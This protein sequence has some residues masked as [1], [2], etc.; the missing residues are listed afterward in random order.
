M[1][2]DTH[3][4]L[5]ENAFAFDRAD[6]VAAA[7]AAGVTRIVTIGTTL[8]SSR[9]ALAITQ[10]F[11][12]VFAA[13][14]IHPN[15]AAVAQPDDWR[16][17][18]ELAGEAKVVAVGETGLDRYWDHTPIDVQQDYF[19]RHLE[20]SR[21]IGKP[22]IVHCRDAETDTI[23]QLRRA[24]E[25]QSL[26][27]VMHSFAGSTETADSCLDLGLYLSFSGMVT[28]KK[29]EELRQI[30]ARVPADRILVETDSPYLAPVPNRGKR[31]EP[32]W[33]RHTAEVIAQVRGIPLEEFAAQTT[34]NAE[35][36]FALPEAGR[37]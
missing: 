12:G 17:V 4:H 5:D 11:P 35:R 26:N 16:M 34:A 15:Y 2:I 6:V 22:F 19:D 3:A 25:Q 30:A 36:L 27:G 18:M 21:R 13:I 9:A 37:R 8:E 23:A 14:G 24:A 28:Y 32:A 33:V 10:E 7:A 31:N 1:L 29:S 20:L